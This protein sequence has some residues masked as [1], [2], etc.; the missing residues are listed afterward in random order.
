MFDDVSQE[1]H[2][3]DEPSADVED[4]HSGV[5]PGVQKLMD[6]NQLADSNPMSQ[7]QEQDRLTESSPIFQ[8]HEVSNIPNLQSQDPD[9]NSDDASQSGPHPKRDPTP[10]AVMV[11]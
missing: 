10:D 8:V 5:E 1:N 11:T 4:Q 2:I 3:Q 6:Q 7:V 9:V